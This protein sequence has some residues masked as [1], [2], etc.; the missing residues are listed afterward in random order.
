MAKTH[1]EPDRY[2]AP[3]IEARTPIEAPLVGLNSI[4]PL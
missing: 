1:A 2:E 3:R 4:E